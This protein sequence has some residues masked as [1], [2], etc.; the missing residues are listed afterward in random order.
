MGETEEV[1]VTFENSAPILR[2]EDM[3]ANLQF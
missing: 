1:G 3:K 2:V